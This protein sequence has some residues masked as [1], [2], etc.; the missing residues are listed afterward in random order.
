MSRKDMERNT[1]S[2]PLMMRII[3]VV[4]AALAALLPIGCSV[5]SDMV[6]AKYAGSESRFVD[7]D[8]LRVHYRDQGKGPVL[9]CLHGICS[10]LHTWDGWALALK[11]RYRIVRLDLPGWALTGPA[12]FPYHR[13]AYMKF[14]KQFIDALGIRRVNLA[15]NSLG[16]YYAWNFAISHP[17]RVDGLVLIDPAG[18]PKEVPGPVRLFTMPVIGDL[19]AAVTPKWIFSRFVREVYGDASR[20]KPETLDRYY[21]LMMYDGNRKTCMAIFKELIK[22]SAQEPVGIRAITVPTLIMWGGRDK[23]NPPHILSSI[24]KDL[25]HARVLVYESAGH[26][27]MEEM[28][29][30]TARDADM[31]LRGM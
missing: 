13:E 14:L 28:P 3:E 5:S 18:Y 7:I 1:Y 27:P 20:L 16:G 17:E 15:G 9:L 22:I 4:I 2:A 29:E 21:D 6:A 19:C 30:I 11:D 12:N 24:R 25:P 31:F 8:G 26:V 23:W 10:S